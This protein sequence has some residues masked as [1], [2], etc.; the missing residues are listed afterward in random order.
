F[1]QAEPGQLEAARDAMLN[2]LERLSTV[3]FT[4]EEVEKAK[5]RGR[6]AQER[7]QTSSSGMAQALSSASARGDWRLL[8]LQRDA[9]A[10]VTAADVNRVAKTYFRKANRTVGLYI[11]EDRP[12]RLAIPAAP[13]LEA[14]V[15]NY[16]GGKTEAAGEAFDP[17]PANLDA[18]TRIV[19]LGGIKAGLL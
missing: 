18:R 7:L 19:D 16:K 4:D 12:Q 1:A 5:V 14:L 17:S 6:R 8:F 3:S 11:P 10:A 15:K 9:Q 13:S 2:T